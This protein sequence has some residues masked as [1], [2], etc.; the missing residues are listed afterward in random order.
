MQ[1][2]ALNFL[3]ISDLVVIPINNG[4]GSY[5]GLLD[6]KNSLNYICRKE[7]REVPKLKILLN[8]VKEE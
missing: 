3:I 2:L 7:N 5:K 6:L 1:E 8:N 4:I